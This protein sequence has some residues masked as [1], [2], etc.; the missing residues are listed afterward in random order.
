MDPEAGTLEAFYASPIQHPGLLWLAAGI[1]IAFCL[2]KRG[3]SRSLRRY[4]V[5][6]AILS[7]ADAWLTSSPVFGLGTLQ[8]WLASGVPLFFVLAGD[9]RYLFFVLTA[10]AGGEIEPRA[11]S[12]LVA[13]GLTFIV[14]ILSQVAL[15]LLPDSLASARMLFLIY[16]VGFVVL[17][18]SLMRW[19]P[20]IR[21]IPWIGSVSRF[22]VLYYSLWASADLLILT[23]GW[24]LG[25]GLRV[26]PNLLYYG[27][28]I[29]TFAWFAPREP[30]P[31]AR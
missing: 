9:Y 5:T 22:V 26:L 27:G 21:Y 14:P 2:S 29:A 31:Q 15:L 3:L 30:V 10:T 23:T 1:A 19:H 24:D 18:L 8:G 4:C 28:L 6:L 25:Y 11:K 12:L 17:T 13:A 7:F 20:Q 16:E